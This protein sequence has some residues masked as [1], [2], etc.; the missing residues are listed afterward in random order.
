MNFSQNKKFHD[1]SPGTRKFSPAIVCL[2]SICGR[3][4]LQARVTFEAVAAA[5]ACLN[6]FYIRDLKLQTKRGFNLKA[7]HDV[8]KR[9]AVLELDVVEQEVH[10]RLTVDWDF[11]IATIRECKRNLELLIQSERK[12]IG[13]CFSV[14]PRRARN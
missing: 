6:V 11:Q 13:M 4:P 12:S 2:P 10:Q 8:P 3:M 14:A 5:A 7:R 9:L 1:N